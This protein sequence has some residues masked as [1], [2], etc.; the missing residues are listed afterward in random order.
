MLN[1]CKNL[2]VS[3][4]HRSRNFRHVGIQHTGCWAVK[5][6]NPV[7]GLF[8]LG[9]YIFYCLKLCSSLTFLTLELNPAEL[10]NHVKLN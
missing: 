1:D 9:L 7:G 5:D 8:K 10:T 2:P 3:Q 6:P 4:L